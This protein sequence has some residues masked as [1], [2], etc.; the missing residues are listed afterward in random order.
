MKNIEIAKLLYEMK[1]GDPPSLHVGTKWYT[2]WNS[3]TIE[4]AWIEAESVSLSLFPDW[5]HDWDALKTLLIEQQFDR[6]FIVL[7]D[8][9]N[10]EGVDANFRVEIFRKRDS[11]FGYG[12]TFEEAVL[13][14][15]INTLTEQ[16]K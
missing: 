3:N 6:E 8:T 10:D 13:D 15:I 5:E 2:M 14:A 7:L 9:F 12:S 11:F 4:E 16:S 1:P